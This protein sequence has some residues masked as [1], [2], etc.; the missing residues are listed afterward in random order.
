MHVYEFAA[1]LL[2]R[3][4]LT[5]NKRIGYFTISNCKWELVLF[6]SLDLEV[7]LFGTIASVVTSYVVLS[8]SQKK[9]NIMKD[10]FLYS[11][12]I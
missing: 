5:V 1:S 2:A 3:D 12:Y 11:M 4:T 6:F 8:M 7:N 10:I 9:K